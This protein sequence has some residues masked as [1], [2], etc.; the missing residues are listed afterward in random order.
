MEKKRR[1]VLFARD[2]GVSL[3]IMGAATLLSM[4]LSRVNDDNNPFAVSVYILAVTLIARF[5]E[6]YFFGAVSSFFALVLVNTLFSRPFG[7]FSMTMPG[8]PLT[9]AVMLIVSLLISALTAQIKRQQVLRIEAEREKTRA[10]L[11]RAIAHDLRT[12]LTSIMGASSTLL[13]NGGLEKAEQDELLSEIH[14]DAR[15]LMRVTENLLTVTKFSAEGAV[16]RKEEE[17]VDE[18]VSGAVVKFGRN[19]PDMPVSSDM[20]E[21]ILLVPMDGV[22]IEQ[23]LINLLENAA[24]HAPGAT[25]VQIAVRDEKDCVSFMVS[26]D[27]AGIDPNALGRIFDGVHSDGADAHGRRNMGIGLSVC[28]TII[29]A[30][31]GRIWAENLKTGGAAFS[32]TLPKNAENER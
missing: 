29:R 19:Y 16:L 21:E 13:E 3:L 8:Y 9:F 26:D 11:L 20:P 15:W 14:S 1:A 18:I 27:G 30:H 5:T 22:L 17:V 6:G 23:V 10:N 25:C 7:Q 12:P 31:G 24:V 32:F 2:L 4:G 28:R